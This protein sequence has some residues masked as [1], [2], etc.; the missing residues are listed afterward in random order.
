MHPE[1]Q[2]SDRNTTEEGV[3]EVLDA[4]ETVDNVVK[5]VTGRGL[6]ANALGMHLRGV[7]QAL[8][9]GTDEQVRRAF[10]S[11]KRHEPRTAQHVRVRALEV[12]FRALGR[13]PARWLY[14]A[15]ARLRASA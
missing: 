6:P 14:E 10:A 5:A 13:R 2:L 3:G 7:T 9:Y 1:D 11:W 12:L 4:M 15:Y 8:R